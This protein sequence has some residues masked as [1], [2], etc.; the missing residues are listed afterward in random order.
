MRARGVTVL[1]LSLIGALA[2]VGLLAVLC[3][4]GRWAL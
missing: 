1:F 2:T 4:A 3:S